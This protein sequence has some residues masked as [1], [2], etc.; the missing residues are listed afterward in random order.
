[1]QEAQRSKTSIFWNVWVLLSM[2][3][4]WVAW[5]M[6]TFFIAIISFIWTTGSSTDN[7]Q[8]LQ[9]KV[10]CPVFE[11]ADSENR[12]VYSVPRTH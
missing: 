7:P 3:A 1:M 8:V 5:S 12:V 9:H 6:I 2:P 4:V 10:R 11:L